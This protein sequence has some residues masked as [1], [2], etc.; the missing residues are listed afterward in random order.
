MLLPSV[1]LHSGS[2]QPH[3]TTEGPSQETDRAEKLLQWI[4]QQDDELKARYGED[5]E[6][7]P[8]PILLAKMAEVFGGSGL[9]LASPGYKLNQRSSTF[10]SSASVPSSSR[11]RLCRRLS[12]KPAAATAESPTPAAAAA[13]PSTPAAAAAAEPSSSVTAS[14]E[15]PMLVVSQD[16]LSSKLPCPPDQMMEA[17]RRVRILAG[18]LSSLLDSNGSPW[19]ILDVLNQLRMY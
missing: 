10:V 1:F 9:V 6:I 12:S 2:I 13:E 11:R 5:I 4:Q 18:L 17:T 7:E 14:A 15:Q 8:S 3:I 16:E 19:R